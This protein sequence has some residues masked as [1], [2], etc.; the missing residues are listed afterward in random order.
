MAVRLSALW[1]SRPLPPVRFLVLIP[2]RGWVYPKAIV[3]LEGLLKLK[4]STSPWIEPATFRLVALCHN[5]IRC[6]VPHT[7]GTGEYK[8]WQWGLEWYPKDL[9]QYLTITS[10]AVVIVRIDKCSL[11]GPRW[12][13][14]HRRNRAVTA[15]AHLEDSSESKTWSWVPGRSPHQYWLCW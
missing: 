15:T 1:A 8:Y 5:W 2:V 10:T 12:K 6:R 7:I 3:R 14:G 11:S 9:P 13:T 4:K